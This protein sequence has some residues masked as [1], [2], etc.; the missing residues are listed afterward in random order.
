MGTHAAA[1]QGRARLCARQCEQ[2]RREAR[3]DMARRVLKSLRTIRMQGPEKRE[4]GSSHSGGAPHPPHHATAVP[5]TSPRCPFNCPGRATPPRGGARGTDAAPAPR[6]S[7]TGC[8]C[9]SSGFLRIAVRGLWRGDLT[10]APT[11]PPPATWRAPDGAAPAARND[12]TA[13]F[14]SGKHSRYCPHRNY[15]DVCHSARREALCGCLTVIE[16]ALASEDRSREI[17]HRK[18]GESYAPRNAITDPC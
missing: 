1:G 16:P 17:L 7:H 2:R 11:R 8:S 9:H 12:S 13:P 10:A 5:M 15:S 14:L 18:C 4:A 3:L 6:A